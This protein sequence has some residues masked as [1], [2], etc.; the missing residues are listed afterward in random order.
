MKTFRELICWEL[1]QDKK[2]RL[3]PDQNTIQDGAE[4][5]RASVL[6]K[7]RYL[8]LEAPGAKTAASQPFG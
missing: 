8:G 4:K 1:E 5:L 6:R 7:V 2:A 3:V